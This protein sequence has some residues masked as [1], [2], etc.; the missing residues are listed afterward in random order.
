MTRGGEG[1]GMCL[2]VKSRPHLPPEV[3]TYVQGGRVGM[4]ATH[5]GI[6]SLTPPVAILAPTPPNHSPAAI[7]APRLCFWS[8]VSLSRG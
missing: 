6:V 8:E 1:L 7:L 5:Y 2:G 4:N 3:S